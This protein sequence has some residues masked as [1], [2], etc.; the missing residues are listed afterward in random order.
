MRCFSRQAYEKGVVIVRCPSCDARH[1]V[2]DR[3]GWFGDRGSVEDFLKGRGRG[4]STLIPANKLYLL[5]ARSQI[6][7]VS[8]YRS[9]GRHSLKG[10]TGRHMCSPCDK[11]PGSQRIFSRTT[12]CRLA[13]SG[14]P[15]TPT[16]D[17]VIQDFGLEIRSFL[18]KDSL[19]SAFMLPQM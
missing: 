3:L 7:L 9:V 16:L 4:V 18:G 19:T 6:L 13:G 5:I 1:L 10:C 17:P 2:A 14:R 11:E 12:L 15:Y 8:S